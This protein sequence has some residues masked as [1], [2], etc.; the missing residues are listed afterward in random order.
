MPIPGV[1]P[2][3]SRDLLRLGHQHAIGGRIRTAIAGSVTAASGPGEDD[4]IRPR[5]SRTAAVLPTCEYGRNH[6][7]PAGSGQPVPAE[8]IEHLPVP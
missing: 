5:I 1:A 2:P 4:I 3:R 7:S 8:L 6:S